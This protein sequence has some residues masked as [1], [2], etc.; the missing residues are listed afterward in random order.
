MLNGHTNGHTNGK[1]GTPEPDE[2]V[3]HGHTRILVRAI[4]NGWL[5]DESK[6][7]EAREELSRILVDPTARA[8][9]RALAAKA[10]AEVESKI[11][12]LAIRFA[13]FEDRTDRLDK[14]GA[15][16]ERVEHMTYDVRMPEAR[17]RI[18]LD[19]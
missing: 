16:T 7:L 3:R 11:A 10:L 19:D 2:Y 9:T 4:L 8:G 1:A 6:M 17:A 13:E 12:E 14:P 5:K 18:G 15:A